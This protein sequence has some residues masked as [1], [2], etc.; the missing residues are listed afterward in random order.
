ML[1]GLR[2]G[3]IAAVVVSLVAPAAAQ[4]K[5]QRIPESEVRAAAAALAGTDRRAAAAAATS[6]GLASNRSATA[7]LIEALAGG[8]APEVSLAALRALELR[9]D[10]RARS[11]L[12]IY[13]RHR[14]PEH[15]AAAMAALGALRGRRTD[16]VIV[17]GLSDPVRSVRLAAARAIARRRIRS[18]VKPLLALFDRGD[19]VAGP[20]LAALGNARLA[21]QIAERIG[22]DVSGELIAACLGAMLL[23]P[24]FGPDRARLEVVKALGTIAGATAI[25]KLAAYVAATSS[26]PPTPSRAEAERLLGGRL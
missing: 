17:A 4:P 6:L 7:P 18:A 25:E 24:D 9:A 1:V 26:Q 13:A 19:P 10:G 12:E 2:I 14:R 23:R 15:R 5:R 22:G 8:L 21:K 11:V 16:P 20:A 3:I